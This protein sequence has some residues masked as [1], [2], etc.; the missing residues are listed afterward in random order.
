VPEEPSQELAQPQQRKRESW[1]SHRR[2]QTSRSSPS[3]SRGHRWQPK[4]RRT[5]TLRPTHTHTH[6]PT[7]IRNPHTHTHN[8]RSDG[9]SAC[10]HLFARGD[11][12]TVSPVK[13][14]RSRPYFCGPRW[15]C[16]RLRHHRS[17]RRG[18]PRQLTPPSHTPDHTQ[19]HNYS[20]THLPRIIA[21]ISQTLVRAHL[22]MMPRQ[23]T[24]SQ[25]QSPFPY[26]EASHRR[27]TWGL[28]TRVKSGT[29]PCAQ[30]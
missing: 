21:T 16:S 13:R 17:R 20:L 11:G 4:T 25:S 6:Q 23:V 9:S 12:H 18:N 24:G 3:R 1:R 7:H 30:C 10:C 2:S 8:R 5:S 29:V 28:R 22:A 14:Y 15:H 19:T 27:A 26:P